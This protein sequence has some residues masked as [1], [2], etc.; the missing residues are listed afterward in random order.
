MSRFTLK[1]IDTVKGRIKIYKLLIDDNCE[2]D[3]LCKSLTNDKRDDVIGSIFATLEAYSNLQMLPGTRFKE[4]KRPK[5]DPIKDYEIKSGNYR[6][7]MFKD[8][9]GGI[10]V[11]GAQ[12]NTQQKDIKRLRAIKVDYINTTTK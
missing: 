6:V 3:K 8:S 11:F 4:L 1:R 12:K 2:F 5:S 10:V 9:K 7:Y